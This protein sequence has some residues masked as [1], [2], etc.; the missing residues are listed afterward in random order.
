MKSCGVILLLLALTAVALQ[1]QQP[2]DEL[3]MTY[4]SI[5]KA[6]RAGANTTALTS[7]LDE[8]VNLA[9]NRGERIDLSRLT[10]IREK[11]AELTN[12]ASNEAMWN[13][14]T[15]TLLLAA[16]ILLMVAAYYY[17]FKK[18]RVW[19]FWLKIRG[20]QILRIR[21]ERAKRSSMLLDDEV[22][23]VLAAILVIVMVFAAAQYMSAG[24]VA[25]PFSELGLLGK[26][27]KLADYPSNLTVGEKALVY[28]YVG[29]RM[30]YPMFYRLEAKLGNKSVKVNPSPVSPFWSYYLILEHNTSKVIPLTF[31]LNKTGMYRLIIELWAYNET[32][33]DFQYDKRWVQLWI[34][35]THP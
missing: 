20:K 5:V 7:Q 3:E 12:L 21:K 30:G 6:S 33:R 27:K 29:N 22:R 15:I 26:N 28:I 1:A 9:L 32:I 18:E 25:E 23:A 35:V 13:S 34:N 17:L 16:S 24:K 14:I 19:R 11:A 10:I 4:L 2:I 31:S 8:L